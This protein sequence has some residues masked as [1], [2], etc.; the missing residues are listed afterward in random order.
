MSLPVCFTD[1]QPCFQILEFVP[2]EKTLS[3]WKQFFLSQLEI[4]KSRLCFSSMTSK[5]QFVG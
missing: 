5:V 4:V 1:S 2:T 3:F